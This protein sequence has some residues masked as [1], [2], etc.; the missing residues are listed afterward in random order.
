MS[1]GRVPIVIAGATAS[2]KSAVAMELA[3]QLDGEI[4][5]VDSMQVYR[6]LDIGTAKATKEERSKIPHHL[7]DILSLDETFNAA[8]FV[9]AA[10]QCVKDI[11]SRNCVPIFCGGT[12]L[13][14]KAWRE[15]LGEAP[16]S[17]ESLRLELEA[18]PLETLL[19]EL[20]EKDPTTFDR[21]DQQ[22]P[23]RVVRAIEVIRL[24]GKPFSEQRSDWSSKEQETA[25]LREAQ[26][27]GILRD[28]DD[29]K[30]RI[31]KR[32]D[33][34]FD[35]GLTEET[36]ELMKSGLLQ[37]NRTAMQAIGYRQVV[38]HLEGQRN[39]E[40]TIELIKSR[41]WKFA[42]RQHTWFRKFGGLEWA[43]AAPDTSSFQIASSIIE[44]TE[45]T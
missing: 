36:R 31:R 41:T 17:D 10:E 18:I 22:N 20:K 24:T 28:M 16:P 35:Q 38:E 9:D 25:P 5:S 33:I 21:I 8:Q 2:G 27:F 40:D 44:S 12:G 43:N 42:R 15:G 34:M 11:Q 7:I 30:T 14:L 6:G 26:C 29:L 19:I 3:R 45:G 37:Q 1:Q 23:R 13:Y 32:V 39:L 4:I